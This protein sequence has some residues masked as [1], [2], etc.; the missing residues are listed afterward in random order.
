MRKLTFLF[1][2][3]LGIATL[4]AQTSGQMATYNSFSA[5]GGVTDALLNYADG[6]LSEKHT[7]SSVVND[8]FI[9]GSPYISN[10]FSPTPLYYKNDVV[11]NVFYRYNALNEEV[12][13]MKTNVEGETIR[14]L[15][16]DKELNIR[17]NGKKMSFKTF[18]TASD[19]TVNGYLTELVNGDNY[20][21]YKRIHVKFSEARAPKNTFEKKVPARFTK[22]VEFY[23][24]KEGINRIDQILPKKNKLVSLLDAS[25]KEA[26]KQFIKENDLNLKNE[27]DMVTL[28]Q[29]LN[30]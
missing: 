18:I 13:I 21:L 5:D 8:Q 15:A 19:R 27:A 7:E 16:K 20:D 2:V 24:Q 25:T 1:I 14:G 30:K 26:A 23:I 17:P 6:D 12:E 10:S 4:N 3:A 28:F 22:Y 9:Q 11:G 29:F